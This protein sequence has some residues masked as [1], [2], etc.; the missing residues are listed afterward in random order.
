MN[1]Q[2]NVGVGSDLSIKLLANIIKE[3]T[4]YRGKIV[5]DLSK[6]EG[7]GKKLLNNKKILS[8]G[9]KPN[10]SLIDGLKKTYDDFLTNK[11]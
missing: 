7:V 9:W 5:F 1:S 6:L 2:V 11:I 3:I 8:F 10:H 4:Q